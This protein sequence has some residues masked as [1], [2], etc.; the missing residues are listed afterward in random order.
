M[1]KYPPPPGGESYQPMSFGEKRTQKGE[2]KKRENVL[3][4]GRKGKE[5]EKGKEKGRGKKIRKGG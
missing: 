3:E 2:E 4:K 5:K 1:E